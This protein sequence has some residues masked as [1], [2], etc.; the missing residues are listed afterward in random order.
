ML[1]INNNVLLIWCRPLLLQSLPALILRLTIVTTD[2]DDDDPELQAIRAR[3]MAELQR[4]QTRPQ[5]TASGASGQAGQDQ[6]QKEEEM[7]NTILTQILSQEAGAR[8][9]SQILSVQSH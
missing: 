6:R 3:R 9:E 1:T 2:M 4:Q 5:T 7:R 8:R